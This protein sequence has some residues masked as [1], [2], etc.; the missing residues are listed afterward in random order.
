MSKP[1]TPL[2]RPWALLTPVVVLLI[3]LPLLRPLRH[4]GRASMAE[5]ATLATARAVAEKGQLH[6]DGVEGVDVERLRSVGEAVRRGGTDGA[7]YAVRPPT[8]AVLLAG[9]LWGIERLGLGF[10]RHGELAAYLLTLIGTTLPT[11]IGAGLI[12]RMG[13]L[14]ELPRRRRAGLAL[15]AALAGGWVSYATVLN[16]HA[17]AAALLVASAAALLYVAAKRRPVKSFWLYP[18]AGLAAGLAAALSPAALPVGAMLPGMILAMRARR[19]LRAAG[20]ALFLLGL[21]PAVALH[22]A[23]NAPITGDWIPA[24][25]HPS[26]LPP[27]VE[28]ADLAPPESVWVTIGG[29]VNALG[30]VIAGDHG[31]LSHFPVLLVAALGLAAVL[32][33]HWPAHAKA[34]AAAVALGAVLTT[35]AA[36]LGP[37]PEPDTFANPA[38]L[39]LTPLALLFA[40]AW[41]R[42][43]HARAAWIAAALLLL[44]SVAVTLVGT[45][46]PAPPEGYA[47]YTA[48]EAAE[49][50]FSPADS[51]TGLAG[52]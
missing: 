39:V 46:D 45:A 51:P 31:P 43:R 7:T 14:F 10:A 26:F 50:L 48:A 25:Y 22:V 18:F 37:R 17:P 28:F 12:Y 42:G 33:R 23:L 38:F 36:W 24:A 6:L 8:F 34:L 5:R 40:G 44:V 13:R 35:A 3:A 20:F 52:R 9:P 2:V 27:T 4:P 29:R 21:T 16:P 11:A 47:R 19:R 32:H 30:R 49:R 15:V 1:R 41:L